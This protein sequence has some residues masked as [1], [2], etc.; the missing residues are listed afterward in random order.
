MTCYQRARLC[1]H[2][3]PS[4]FLGACCWHH[5]VPRCSRACFQ[6]HWVLQWGSCR[7]SWASRCLDQQVP[8]CSHLQERRWAWQCSLSWGLMSKAAFQVQHWALLARQPPKVHLC[9]LPSGLMSAAV[10]T[11]KL[12][13][14]SAEVLGQRSVL[15]WAAELGQVLV[16]ESE[17][18]SVR[19][20]VQV[21]A[22]VLAQVLVQGWA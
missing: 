3:V 2:Q 20:L 14:G 15:V 12:A 11:R 16:Q 21:S 9:S 1:L 10:S 19:V 18:G 6:T 13:W 5:Q 4:C 22:Q 7:S 17:Q 8:P